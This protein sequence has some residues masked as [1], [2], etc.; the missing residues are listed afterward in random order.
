MKRGINHDPGRLIGLAYGKIIHAS[1]HIEIIQWRQTCMIISVYAEKI[2]E[3]ITFIYDE[4]FQQTRIAN[5]IHTKKIA[6]N[7]I[8]SGEKMMLSLMTVC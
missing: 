4:T 8:L 3:R 6:A 5:D 1:Y 7:F 2:F